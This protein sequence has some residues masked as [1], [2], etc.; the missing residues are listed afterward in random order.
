MRLLIQT[1]AA[2][3]DGDCLIVIL[4]LLLREGDV[5]FCMYV[6]VCVCM[7]EKLILEEIKKN[8]MG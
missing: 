2:G 5:A 7:L 3:D 4:L 8:G 1:G 6:C